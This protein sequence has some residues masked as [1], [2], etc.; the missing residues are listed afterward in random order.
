M[1]AFGEEI[2]MLNHFLRGNFTPPMPDAVYIFNID[3]VWLKN[4][5]KW[6]P[7]DA[8]RDQL[9]KTFLLSTIAP[10]WIRSI[11]GMFSALNPVFLEA[12]MPPKWMP[13]GKDFLSSQ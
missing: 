4:A 1:D 13:Q 7:Y 12:E 10:K 3:L 11:T 5:P 6:I 2:L 8:L 9:K